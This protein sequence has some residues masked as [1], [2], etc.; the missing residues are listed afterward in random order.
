MNEKQIVNIAIDH[1]FPHP[2]NPR[3]NLGD[4]TEIAESIR[5][6]GIMQNL[7]VVPI[8][9]KP[10]DYMTLIG[11]RRCAGAKLAGVK[12]VPCIIKEGLSKNEQILI[13]LEENMQRSD[14]TVFEQA[15]SFQMMLDLGETETSIA[16]K[17]GFSK[18]TVR[19][20]L[21]IAKLDQKELQKKEK[22][23]S[24]QLTIKDLME[25]E[26]IP[27]IKTR[28]KILK[29]ASNSRDLVARAQSAAAEA[30]RKSCQK[31]ICALL[32]KP[33]LKRHRMERSMKCIPEN[34]RR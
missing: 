12:E 18:T 19:H 8:E 34:G 21:N 28:D 2:D 13:M 14:L 10:G 26:K 15:Q 20:R 24:F 7:T 17:T 6:R 32:K 16:E 25:L 30:A 22:D 29:D 5:K 23:D 11:H 31:A 3:K 4:L 9:G 1:I 27:D 33:A